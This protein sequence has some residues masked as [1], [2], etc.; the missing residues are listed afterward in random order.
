MF[1]TIFQFF[2]D[3]FKRSLV[4][5]YPDT[6]VVDRQT[7][8]QE[9][10][11]W[12][13]SASKTD[14]NLIVVHFPS[15]FLKVQDS[16]ERAGLPY[17]I[18]TGRIQKEFL[19]KQLV[20]QR[21]KRKEGAATKAPILLALSAQIFHPEYSYS[22]DWKKHSPPSEN[23]PVLSVLVP[24]IHPY[25]EVSSSLIEFCSMLAVRVD[26]GFFVALDDE[27]IDRLVDKR[28]ILLME[29]MGIRAEQVTGSLFF[30]GHF[31]KRL[32][33]FADKRMSGISAD[34]PSQWFENWD[35]QI[36]ITNENPGRR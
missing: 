28:V 12:V 33:A 19:N 17:D 10:P 30:F 7:I 27:V 2:A 18:Q 20:Q 6:L 14:L 5:V 29:E 11:Q 22:D 25:E 36:A 16:L 3:S 8:Y 24:E 4:E 31:R 1:R 15:T 32:K 23:I 26:V 13:R 21:R 35:Q 9:I 34:S